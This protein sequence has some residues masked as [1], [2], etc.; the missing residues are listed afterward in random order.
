MKVLAEALIYAIHYIE[1]NQSSN[2]DSDIAALEAI[3]AAL[4]SATVEEKVV[5][6]LEAK[7]LGYPELP[8]SLGIYQ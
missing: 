4:H 3:C 8:E 5:F 2:P 7:R 1:A 6:K